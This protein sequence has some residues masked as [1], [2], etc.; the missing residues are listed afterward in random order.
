MK[1]EEVAQVK[2][3]TS[4]LME[5]LGPSKTLLILQACCVLFGLIILIFVYIPMMI[6]LHNAANRLHEVQTE[7]L[8]QRGAIASLAIAE[9]TEKG[10][11]LGL[12]FSSIS[13]SQLQD[14]TQAGIRKLPI[15]FTIESEYKNVGQFLA[16][17]EGFTRS[18]TEVESLS[19]HPSQNNLPELS[20]ELVLNLYV[21][22]ENET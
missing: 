19:I 17:V 1:T 2:N 9:L 22:I 8:N 21:G 13:P 15:S 16:F 20:V 10:R 7:L 6:K 5:S 18:I 4:K 11:A 14:T 3:K 12:N